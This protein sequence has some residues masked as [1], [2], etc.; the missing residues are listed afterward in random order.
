MP[1]PGLRPEA[2]PMTKSRQQTAIS[3]YV[4]GADWARTDLR[5]AV[6]HF[7]N[8]PIMDTEHDVTGPNSADRLA[9]WTDGRWVPARP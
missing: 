1:Y 9:A 2:G 6:R 7:S 4:T 8:S 3:P 5:T